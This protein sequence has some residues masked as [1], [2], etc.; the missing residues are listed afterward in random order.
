MGYPVVIGKSPEVVAAAA[1]TFQKHL[2]ETLGAM[3][4][5]HTQKHTFILRLRL[6][7]LLS[8][9]DVVFGGE[10]S[11]R[12]SWHC[13]SIDSEIEGL[14]DQSSRLLE[15]R[16]LPLLSVIAAQVYTYF[17]CFPGDSKWLKRLVAVVA[18]GSL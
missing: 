17:K 15:L 11:E 10:Y 8:G 4:V 1:A 9:S 6:Q 14:D 2:D 7:V 5:R 13:P 3:S 18:A 16:T 12:V